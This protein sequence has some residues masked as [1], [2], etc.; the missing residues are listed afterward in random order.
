MLLFSSKGFLLNLVVRLMKLYPRTRYRGSP[1]P[2]KRFPIQTSSDTSAEK[3]AVT[4]R[5]VHESPVPSLVSP[6]CV[7][8]ISAVSSSSSPYLIPSTS[9]PKGTEKTVAAS[10]L[11]GNISLQLEANICRDELLLNKVLR[12]DCFEYIISATNDV[13]INV[14]FKM[15][16]ASSF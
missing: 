3:P 7:L 4:R 5:N 13:R 8:D 6:E 15:R 10:R 16:N 1:Q 14:V 12:A 9:Q 11:T 2:E